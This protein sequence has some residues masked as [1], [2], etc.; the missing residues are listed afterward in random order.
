MGEAFAAPTR[1]PQ[2]FQLVKPEYADASIRH[3]ITEKRLTEDDAALIREYIGEMRA[4]NGIGTA[5]ANKLTFALVNWLR[6][7][8]PYRS[9]T[10]ADLYQAVHVIKSATGPR[11]RPLRWKRCAEIRRPDQRHHRRRTAGNRR[12]RPGCCGRN[13]PP[14]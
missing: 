12:P 9:N 11:G 2:S 6:F 5:R 4:S 8:G 1:A 7:I 3:A 13:V 14:A 10:V